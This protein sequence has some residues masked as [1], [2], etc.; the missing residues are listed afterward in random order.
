MKI[1]LVVS[2]ML[3]FLCPNAG[4]WT[5]DGNTYTTDG[6]Q[7]DVESAI[8]D[9]SFGDTVKLPPGRYTW[10]VDGDRVIID[11][12]ITLEGAGQDVTYLIES[13]DLGNWQNGSMIGV[14][15]AATLKSFT[16]NTP[17]SGGY[18]ESAISCGGVNGWRVTDIKY[19]SSGY[20]GYFLYFGSYGL[21]DNCTIIGSDGGEEPVFGRGPVDSWQTDSS[22]GTG[23]AFYME[24]C[25]FNGR[26]YVID[27]NSNARAVIRYNTMNGNN[28]VDG[29]GLASNGSPPRGV[30]HMEVYGNS[31][32]STVSPNWIAITLRGGTGYVWGNTKAVSSN[33]HSITVQEYC[34]TQGPRWA[35]CGN[36]YACRIDYPIK[37]QVGVGKDPKI[38]ASEPAMF[39]FNRNGTEAVWQVTEDMYGGVPEEAHSACGEEYEFSTHII[40]NDRDFFQE[41]STFVAGE[42]TRLTSG[43]GVGTKAQMEMIANCMDGCGFWVTDEADW[44]AR[45]AGPDGQFYECRSNAW[46]L[47]YTPYTYP[48]PLRSR[49]KP[50]PPKKLRTR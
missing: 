45:Q 10:G 1:T 13:A 7:E 36:R 37:D 15:A 4:G 50:L 16:I 27:A 21:L 24:D 43:I 9:A 49:A 22:F 42:D 32:T 6:S 25:T 3:F 40:V 19:V 8:A 11:K 48:H 47:K 20:F 44:N 14:T 39:F 12:A 28:K 33:Y 30:R 34:C 38:G 23:D 26:G 35:N 17:E 2:I 41:N 5:L 29:H 46:V 18:R 31:W